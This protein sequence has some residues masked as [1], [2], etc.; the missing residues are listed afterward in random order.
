M[1]KYMFFFIIFSFGFAQDD[2]SGC[3]DSYAANYN[4]DASIDDGSCSGYLDNGDYSLSFG[5]D[6]DY[7]HLDWSE[8]M[9][10]YTIS[11]WVKSN[12]ESQGTFDAF[13]NTY[14]NPNNGLQLDCNGSNNYRF[15]TEEGSIVIAP[16]STEWSHIAV[17]A[18]NS[19]TTGYFNGELINYSN[20]VET[21]WNQIELGRN[22][23]VN[24]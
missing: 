6:G 12:V 5:G 16:L 23:N 7:T 9:S 17:V 14:N 18:D 20:W 15:H 4:P 19:T 22:R 10:S 24:K 2:I 8:N 3:T 21:D 11:I 1:A 13:F